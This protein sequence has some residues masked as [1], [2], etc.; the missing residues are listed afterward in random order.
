MVSVRK[1]EQSEAKEVKRVAKRAF[2]GLEQ[3]S[4]SNPKEALVAVL[5]G[6]IV[7][8]III[9]Y[10][11]S[12]G[13]KIGYFDAAFID[14]KHHGEGIGRTLYQETTRY[15]GEQGCTVLS[16]IVKDDNVGSWKLLLNNGFNQISLTEGV[17]QLGFLGMLSHYFAT[18]LFACNGMELY[19]TVKDTKV[20]SKTSQSIP[21]IFLY[22]LANMLLLFP[23]LINKSSVSLFLCSY[24]TLLIGGVIFGYA[25]T[26]FSKKHWTFRLNSG[27]ALI[28]VFI[29]LIGGLYPMIGNWYPPQYENTKSFRKDMGIAALCEWISIIFLTILGL[30]L[31]LTHPYFEY[32]FRIGSMLLLYRIIIVYPFESYGGNRVYRWSKKIYATL[33]AVSATLIIIGN[34]A[35]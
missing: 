12:G 15:L 23:A 26:L 33:T 5:D 21:Q 16:A 4:V 18:P 35:L 13:Q 3:F 34:F 7:G 22:L 30:A 1:M 31:Q 2:G 24:I 25:G 17:R 19:L 6:K 32:L 11:Q 27:G 8:G 20:K 9:K 14:P 10:M 28:V 29:T